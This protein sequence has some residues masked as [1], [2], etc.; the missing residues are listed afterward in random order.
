MSRSIA[1]RLLL[2]C[3]LLASVFTGCTRDP[4]A[5]KQKYFDSGDKYF[6]EGKYREAFD[7]WRVLSP[8]LE[9]EAEMRTLLA[10]AEESL[11]AYEASVEASRAGQRAIQPGQLVGPQ[12]PVV[13]KAR[14]IAPASSR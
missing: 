7:Q 4:N 9:N 12:G 5:R 6:A 10:S 1:V 2:S 11:K 14:K 13:R 8:Y 3:S